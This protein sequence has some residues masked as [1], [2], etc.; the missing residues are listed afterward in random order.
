MSTDF[1]KKCFGVLLLLHELGS[2][3]QKGAALLGEKLRGGIG[4]PCFL[5]KSK[6]DYFNL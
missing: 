2:H 5:T 1:Y 4:N 6:I 3:V